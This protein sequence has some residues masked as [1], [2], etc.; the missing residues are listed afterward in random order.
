MKFC[1]QCGTQLDAKAAFC[2]T[3]GTKTI[4]EES[5]LN[6][7]PLGF[8]QSSFR[9][10]I[11]AIR[12]M[13][14]NPKQMIPM[15][16]LSAVWLVLSL[17]PAFGFN[18]LPVQIL[19]FFSFAQGGMYGG[20]LGAVGGIVGK[21]IFA[22]FVTALI[23]PLFSGKK[24][25]NG[26]GTGFKR[27]FAGLA[28]Q[29]VNALALLLTG[30]GFALI[31][32]NFLTGNASLVNSMAGVT[33]FIIAVKGL[34]SKSGFLWGLLLSITN[35]VSNGKVPSQVTVSRMITGFAAGNAASIA[36]SALSIPYLLYAVGSLL[37]IAGIITA[38]IVKPGKEAAAI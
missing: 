9:S 1:T 21:A 10:S 4:L 6:L 17:L 14:K 26:T 25:F 28:V 22:Y 20:L 23:L 2:T 5:Q 33:G 19:S 27:F 31:L 30:F 29:S 32:Y 38:I 13:L 16:V 12:L 18:P 8:V 37:I 34:G 15:L 3:C 7:G 36:L 24:S 35:K 11:S